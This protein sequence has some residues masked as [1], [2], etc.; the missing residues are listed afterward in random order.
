MATAALLAG[1]DQ[2]SH[3]F[4]V[5]Q[6]LAVSLERDE[7]GQGADTYYQRHGRERRNQ[8]QRDARSNSHAGG[9]NRRHAE[10]FALPCTTYEAAQRRVNRLVSFAK[11]C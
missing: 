6:W 4:A 5:A 7:H 9:S 1:H 3:A 11:V 10:R 8:D 2:T